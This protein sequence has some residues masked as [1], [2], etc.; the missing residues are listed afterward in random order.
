MT[1]AEKLQKSESNMTRSSKTIPPVLS[2]KIDQKSK[3]IKKRKANAN[4]SKPKNK[5]IAAMKSE[6]LEL[7][8]KIK[9][10]ENKSTSKKSVKTNS[11]DNKKK[12]GTI[13]TKPIER[14]RPPSKRRDG[15]DVA[16]KIANKKRALSST[17]E[18]KSSKRLR[19]VNSSSSNHQSTP[20]KIVNNKI[21]RT[22]KS[23]EGEQI[24]YIHVG[25]SGER[26]LSEHLAGSGGDKLSLQ[27]LE[28]EQLPDVDFTDLIHGLDQ[29]GTSRDYIE[30][31]HRCSVR[32]PVGCQGHLRPNEVVVYSGWKLGSMLRGRSRLRGRFISPEELD[33]AG[34][35]VVLATLDM[36]P[37]MRKIGGRDK[38][39]GGNIA[40]DRA[41][42]RPALIERNRRRALHQH[43]FRK[44]MEEDRNDSPIPPLPPRLGEV[45]PQRVHALLDSPTPSYEVSTQHSWNPNDRSYNL[46]LKAEDPLVMRRRPVAQS[47]DC[48]RGKTGFLEGIHL[49]EISWPVNQRGTHAVVGVATSAAPLHVQG[50]QSLVGSNDQSWGWDLGRKKAFHSNNSVQFPR[51]ISHHHQWTVPETF[52]MLLD[53]DRG[54]LMFLAD[55]QMLGVSHTD[56]HKDQGPLYPAVSTVWGHCEVRLQYL[57]SQENKSPLSLQELARLTIRTSAQ[58]NTKPT[59]LRF[60]QRI[61]KDMGLP[62]PLRN[63]LVYSDPY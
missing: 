20:K 9:I 61:F 2:K 35:D 54:E 50:Y 60:D 10:E 17:R 18:V 45:V 62:K 16:S 58:L 46:E 19:S 8:K 25:E 22:N 39:Q 44:T 43:R 57:G 38:A 32:C 47:T 48:I 14:K 26:D 7:K 23:S 49:F 12:K 27:I 33:T 36:G 37:N 29:R 4:T 42:R 56:L 40:R 1:K 30:E 15:T 5:K 55:G 51:S 53:M 41:S 34:E 6:I 63:F 11:V 24:A 52:Q 59:L 13:K 3:A 28:E 31:G 21:S